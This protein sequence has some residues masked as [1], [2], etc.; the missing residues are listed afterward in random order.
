MKH[1][2]E[3]EQLRVVIN[4]HGAELNSIIE[5]STNTEYLW[6]GDERYWTGQAIL[7]FPICGRLVEG[8]YTHEGKSYDMTIHGFIR[9]VDLTVENKTDTSITLTYTDNEFTRAQYPFAFR[10]SLTYALDGNKLTHTFVVE[11]TGTE[12][13][14]FGIGGH[15]G[16]N[17]PLAPGKK[18]EDYQLRFSEKCQPEEFLISPRFLLSGETAPYALKD[19]Q[20]IPMRHSLF[21]I[22]AVLL[23]NMAREVT[24]EAEGDSHSVT[25]TYPGMR[26]LAFWHA[27]KTDAPYVCIEPWCSLASFEDVP[28][29][30]E[31]RPDLLRLAP[32]ETYENLWSVR[33]TF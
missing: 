33:C 28:A 27:P 21:D 25:V 10:Y 30:F 2:L 16:F 13:L 7:L 1:V 20:I 26:Y 6:Q 29:I 19:D 17:V 9:D 4:D 14:P 18:F 5:K 11:N 32:G 24:L 12:V 8:R 23:R 15:P 3:N 22:D 31:E